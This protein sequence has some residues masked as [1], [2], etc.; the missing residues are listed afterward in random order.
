MLSRTSNTCL[1]SISSNLSCLE[2]TDS[3]KSLFF[4]EYEIV[5]FIGALYRVLKDLNE[6][7]LMVS[8][9]K[10]PGDKSNLLNVNDAIQLIASN[11]FKLGMINGFFSG[12]N[13]R[14]DSSI[15]SFGNFVSGI[16]NI[17]L[18]I[19]LTTSDNLVSLND[20]EI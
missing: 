9:K 1:N 7:P 17:F 16:F 2:P 15:N 4:G 10:N 13:N 6:Y 20:L 11:G 5:F 12:F 14:V 19:I 8:K 18:A 3:K